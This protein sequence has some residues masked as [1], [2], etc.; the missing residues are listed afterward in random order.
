MTLELPSDLT[1]FADGDVDPF[2]DPGVYV[3]RLSKPADPITAWDEEYDTRPKWFQSWVD[4]DTVL[5]VG[6]ASC[7]LSRLEDYK[8]GEVRPTALTRV[9]TPQELVN[10][11]WYPSPEKAFLRESRHALRVEQETDSDTF[12]HSN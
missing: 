12:V 5:Y 4:A 10:V 7:V 6:A 8:R 3:L 2:N 11:H 9:S 1:A